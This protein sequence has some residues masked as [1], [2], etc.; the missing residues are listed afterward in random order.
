M[1]VLLAVLGTVHAAIAL[2]TGHYS[3]PS[4][5]EALTEDSASWIQSDHSQ[6][7]VFCLDSHDGLSNSE[8]GFASGAYEKFCEPD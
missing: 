5:P 6:G 1:A 8:A 3:R 4:Q 7:H 2:V